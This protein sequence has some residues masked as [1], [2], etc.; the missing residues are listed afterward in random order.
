MAN[1]S[2][3]FK[4]ATAIVGFLTVVFA[5]LSKRKKK[6]RTRTRPTEPPSAEVTEK[7]SRWELALSL[8]DGLNVIA[9]FVLFWL[10]ST[11]VPAEPLTTQ[12]AARFALLVV[13][14]T[15][16]LIRLK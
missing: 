11:V 16:S 1:W 7:R 9:V 13:A 5:L 12:H 8:Y 15:A 3:F 2:E 14:A 10:W 6:K 4:L